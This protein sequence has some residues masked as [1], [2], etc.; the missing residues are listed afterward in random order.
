MEYQSALNQLAVAA[1]R[2]E[3]MAG[4]QVMGTKTVDEEVRERS[5][6][7]R[8]AQVLAQNALAAVELLVEPELADRAR[9][10]YTASERRLPQT[11][12]LR[13]RD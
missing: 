8:Q 13:G 2:T 9:A 4:G 6:A 5:E 1:L 7:L 10:V 3:F 11:G 12:P